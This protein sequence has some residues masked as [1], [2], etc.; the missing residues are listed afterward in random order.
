MPTDF[1]GGK[2]TMRVDSGTSRGCAAIRDSS[3]MTMMTLDDDSGRPE[4][5]MLLR[6]RLAHRFGHLVLRNLERL[7][8]IPEDVVNIL[9]AD[10][11]TDIIIADSSGGLL[12]RTHL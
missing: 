7:I 2:R 6:D 5:F 1:A 3:L 8:Q 4:C 10:G 11:E 9:N 12:F